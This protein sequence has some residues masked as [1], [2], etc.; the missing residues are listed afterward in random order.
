MEDLLGHSE[1]VREVSSEMLGGI[2][3]GLTALARHDP[4]SL[5]DADPDELAQR[6]STVF[7][8]FGQL[9]QS[10]REFYTYLTQVLSRFDLDRSEFQ[11]FKTALLDYL[12]RFV[13]E[14]DKHMPQVADA[15]RTVEPAVPALCKRANAG[16]RLVDLQGRR[17]A[18]RLAW[19]QATGRGCMRGSRD[20]TAATATPRGSVAWPRMR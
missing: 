9:V 20:N 1:T 17:R 14:V 4:A 10:T 5:G 19:T 12:Q 18:G 15:L 2:L 11:L 3:D 6:I 7:A 8:Q 13:A 16:Q